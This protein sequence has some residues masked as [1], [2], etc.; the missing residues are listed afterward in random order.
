[1]HSKRWEQKNTWKRNLA[2][3][4]QNLHL[5]NTKKPL[6][7]SMNIYN[8]AYKDRGKSYDSYSLMPKVTR[9]W[10]IWHV[11]PK[12]AH[13]GTFL[14]TIS[15]STCQM[16][17]RVLHSAPESTFF[18]EIERKLNE[19]WSSRWCTSLMHHWFRLLKMWTIKN[20]VLRIKYAS[21]LTYLFIL[22]SKLL[23]RSSRGKKTNMFSSKQK[24]FSIWIL[25]H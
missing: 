6:H 12:I 13:L 16:T 14:Q 11:D 18:T 5:E 19:L 3:I 2:R 23:A 22:Y 25:E 7:F 20:N 10:F 4:F 1:M 15:R 24:L 17:T 21:L 9:V 8:I